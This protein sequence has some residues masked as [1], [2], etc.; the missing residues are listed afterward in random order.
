MA[1]SNDKL[2]GV[3]GLPFRVTASLTLTGVQNCSEGLGMSRPGMW[4]VSSGSCHCSSPCSGL[5]GKPGEG[6]QAGCSLLCGCTLLAPFSHFLPTPTPIGVPE[7]LQIGVF[8]D[9]TAFSHHRFGRPGV[10]PGDDI[11]DGFSFLV[12]SSPFLYVLILC[13]VIYCSFSR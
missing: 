4:L 10:S 13:N 6:Q 7:K 11:I 9:V 3:C 2:H 5:L 8:K 12:S 1:H